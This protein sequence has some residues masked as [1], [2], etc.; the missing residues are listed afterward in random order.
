MSS[1]WKSVLVV[2]VLAW[3]A[4]LD[5]QESAPLPP[6][7]KDRGRGVASS[8]FGTY[9]GRGELIL[10][11]YWEYYLDNNREYS[12]QELNFTGAQDFRGK[13]RESEWLFFAAYGLTDN[14][15]IQAEVAGARASLRKAPEDL[16]ALPAMYRESGLTS[17]ETQLRLRLRQEDERRP[18]IWSYLDVV[19]PTNKRSPLIGNAGVQSELGLGVTRGFK[20]GTLTARG[21][22]AYEGASNTRFAIGE[23][24]VE[25]L[26]RLSPKWRVFTGINGHETALTLITEAQWHIHRNVFIRFNQEIGL[27]SNANDWEPQLGIL[28]TIPT[29]RSR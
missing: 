28:F 26:K 9:I 14:L 8:M 17:F 11:P 27:T 6:Y 13:Y 16:S 5:A 24:G 7:L 10:Y 25:Y 15:A 22:A 4:P 2:A 21:S 29:A 19:Y 20:W 18:E 3:T 1:T 12:P 23:Y